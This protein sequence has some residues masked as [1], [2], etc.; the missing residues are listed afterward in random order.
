VF[1]V[2]A[3]ASA[4]GVDYVEVLERHSF[5]PSAWADLRR[6]VRD[7]RIDIV[8]A[9]EY[10]TDLVA[11]FL[12]K[13]E[14]VLPLATAHG[15]TGHSKRE[16]WIYYPIDRRL[17]SRFPQVIAVSGEI[18]RTLV[19]SGVKPENVSTIL[20]GIDHDV[21]RRD[22]AREADQRRELGLTAREIV[23]GSVGRL[24]PQKRFDLLFDAVARVRVACPDVC[25][26]LVGD[27]S[28]RANLEARARALFPP[29]HCLMLGERSDVRE[30]HH[31]FDVF[32]QSSDYEGTPN[33]VLEAMALETPIVATDA[34]GTAEIVHDQVHGLIVAPSNVS[35][36]I[37]AI[38]C[39]LR[40]RQGAAARA[41]AARRRVE[42]TLSF[43]ARMRA[44]EDVYAALM[45][46]AWRSTR[47]RPI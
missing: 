11:L 39:A 1:S 26:V 22:R 3:K 34:G 13:T 6:V 14:G 31:A 37:E 10:K 19:R 20:N 45:S 28:L 47:V 12:A 46:S 25:L 33:A 2:G 17:L 18:K 40:D 8:H 7:R 23:I 24:E 15:W 9:H 32:V 38:N 43:D 30:L 44:V 5:D 42:Q 21:F 4:L 41:A 35:A 16:R 29:G 27:G 36:L